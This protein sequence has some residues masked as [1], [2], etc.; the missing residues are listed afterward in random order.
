MLNLKFIQKCKTKFI[1]AK[2][3]LEKRFKVGGLKLPEFKA[4]FK[5]TVIKI[6]C[7]QLLSNY[8]GKV[9]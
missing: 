6:Y 4:C 2:T 7:L 9:E 1:V 3:I 5:A 8:N